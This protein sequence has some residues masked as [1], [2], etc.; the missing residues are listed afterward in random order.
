MANIYNKV[1]EILLQ[2][3]KIINEMSLDELVDFFK[4]LYKIKSSNA[5]NSEMNIV[6]PL[7]EELCKIIIDNFNEECE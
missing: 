4:M 6:K 7:K 3:D 1:N 5:T 2:T